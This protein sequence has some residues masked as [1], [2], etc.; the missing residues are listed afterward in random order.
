LIAFVNWLAYLKPC[1]ARHHAGISGAAVAV[2]TSCVT[3][4]TV[5]NVFE[6]ADSDTG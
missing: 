5:V 3:V 6:E 2:V 1:V 4:V